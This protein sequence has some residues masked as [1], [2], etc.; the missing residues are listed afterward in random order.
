[1]L[2]VKIAFENTGRLDYLDAVLNA[3]KEYD[4]VGFCYDS[5]HQLCYTPDT[6]VM[7]LYGNRLICTHLNDN[8]GVSDF[9]GKTTN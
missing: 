2:G 1:M 4:N 5:G 3:F 6:D 7:E 8:L 9:E